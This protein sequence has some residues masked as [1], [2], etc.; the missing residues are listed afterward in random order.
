MRDRI[1]DQFKPRSQLRRELGLTCTAPG[2]SE[3]LTAFLGPGSDSF[4]RE[5]QINLNTYGGMGNPKRPHTHSRNKDYT[6][7]EC[8]W[9]VLKDPRIASV[10]DES[11][12]RQI[13]R[14]ILHGDHHYTRHADGGDDTPDNIKTLCPICHA[15]KTVLNKDNKKG[16][17]GETNV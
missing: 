1:Y 2:C 8:G 16:N 10:E 9:E 17:K 6:C 14:I 3:P 4:C 7:E 13:G 5:H 11:L 12:K 15:K